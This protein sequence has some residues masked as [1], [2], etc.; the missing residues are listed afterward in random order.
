MLSLTSLFG[1]DAPIL[2]ETDFQFL[3]LASMLPVLGTALLSPVLDSLIGPF[4]ASS[5]TIGLMI[6]VFTAPAIL[7]IPVA[8][9]LADR[10]GR[11]FVLI[12][13]ISLF[14]LSGTAIA[15][16][17]DFQV[18]LAL[19]VLQGIGFAGITPIIITSIGD[20]YTG[21]KEATGQGIR[22]MI[23]GLSGA[24]FPLLAGLLVLLAWHYP[25]LLYAIAF[26]I[27][28]GV[29][30]W[31]DEPTSTPSV[32]TD[33]GEL[34]SYARVLFR[35][36]RQ[37]RVLALV[38]ARALLN[39]IWIGF[40][41]YN[42]LIVIR[43]I[44]GT[45]VQAG[46]LATVG[47]FTLGI[48]ASQAGRITS[49]FQSRLY[50]LIA[51]NV[52]FAVG[53]SMVLFAPGI[54]VAT[55]GITTSCVGFGILGSLYRSIITGLA[56]TDLRAGLVSVSEAGGRLTSTLTPLAMGGAIALASPAIGFAPALRFAGLGLAVVGGGGG[57]ICL[58][59]ASASP[60]VSVE[61]FETS[62][63]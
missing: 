4:G 49:F 44:G 7:M 11:K 18:V 2:R 9:V 47:F 60:P 42:S 37:R 27:A 36:G 30:L 48:S 35:L 20:L 6:S 15:F 26:P 58:L 40:V 43:L 52:C 32:A 39:T 31:F 12:S 56:P 45:P 8:G 38:V 24:V 22:F 50:L 16:T 3:M 63:T 59:V 23:S 51:A 25:F 53:F 5:A 41:T 46:M 34:L 13:S 28:M 17:T 14:G 33:G 1:D 54:G 55:V 10:L 62:N 21:E 57:I 29:Y 19:R 61:R